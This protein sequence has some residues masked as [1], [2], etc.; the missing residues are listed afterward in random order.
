MRDEY[1]FSKAKPNPYVVTARKPVT[2]NLSGVAIDYFKDMAKETG[3]PYHR[4][5][6][7]CTL[8]SVRVSTRNSNS[9]ESDASAEW[10]QR[11]L[12]MAH[13]GKEK[14][15]ISLEISRFQWSG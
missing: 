9:Y 5:S 7:I 6:S 12:K 14:R 4:T 10:G 15:L 2:M 13:D 1:D 11:V 8:C 3:I